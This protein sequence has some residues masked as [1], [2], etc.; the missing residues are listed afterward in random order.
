MDL[1]CESID[2][3]YIK[4]HQHSAGAAGKGDEAIGNSRAGK[5]SKIH[6]VVDSF[7]NPVE[8]V[9]TGGQVHD[10]KMANKLIQRTPAFEFTIA[11]KAYGKQS[12]RD[13]IALKGSEAV[14]PRKSNS[15][16]GND[17]MNWDLYKFRHLVE[18][19][20]ARLKHYR[21]IATR[22]DKLKRNFES[23]VSLACSMMWLSI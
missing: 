14:I 4:A 1:E 10:S 11:D 12:F 9:I 7:G 2:G 21:A 8:F 16:I 5:T 17:D 15:K 18:N 23:M 20:F 22:Y 19:T 13:D 3:S 6:L